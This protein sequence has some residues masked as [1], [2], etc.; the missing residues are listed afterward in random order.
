MLTALVLTRWP[1]RPEPFAS[2]SMASQTTRRV[3]EASASG[4]RSHPDSCGRTPR[5][6][7]VLYSGR[8]R[9]WRLSCEPTA[10]VPAIVARLDDKA[11]AAPDR[12]AD[13]MTTRPTARRA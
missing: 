4:C 7:A 10:A 3:S 1:N 5:A 9:R 11:G 6:A 8:L 13:F 12:D 2:N